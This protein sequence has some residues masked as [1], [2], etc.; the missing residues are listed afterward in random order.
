MSNKEPYYWDKFVEHG[1]K[2]FNYMI[3]NF[4]SMIDLNR[5]KHFDIRNEGVC[6]LGSDE[7]KEKYGKNIEQELIEW[8]KKEYENKQLFNND[9]WKPFRD[10]T[11]FIYSYLGYK[12]LFRYKHYIFQL[13]LDSDCELDD[14]NDCLNNI[15]RWHLA[16][17]LYGWTEEGNENTMPYDRE[18]VLEDNIMPERWWNIK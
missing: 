14:C 9:N 7:V 4:D 17:T 8:I 6:D 1:R 16:L 10:Q 15:N 3:N 18:P 11:L 13:V 12:I 2:L 5:I